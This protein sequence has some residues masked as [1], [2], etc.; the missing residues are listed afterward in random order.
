MLDKVLTP[1]FLIS[2][3]VFAVFGGLAARFRSLMA[4]PRDSLNPPLVPPMTAMMATGFVAMISL[5]H[6]ATILGLHKK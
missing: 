5:I 4:R 3:A 6:M 1:E 2:L